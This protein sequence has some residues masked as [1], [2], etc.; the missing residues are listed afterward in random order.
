MTRRVGR[1]DALMTELGFEK[2]DS[3]GLESYRRGDRVLEFFWWSNAKFA[4]EHNV[5]P[6]SLVLREGGTGFH[7]D[8]A[9]PWQHVAQIITQY[10]DR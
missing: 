8:L 10:I 3:T 6:S 4:A 7:I 2:F 5:P 1:L 9:R